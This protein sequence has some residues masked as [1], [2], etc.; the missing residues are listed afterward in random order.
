MLHGMEG[1]FSFSDFPVHNISE[2]SFPPMPDGNDSKI[3]YS[4]GVALLSL[5]DSISKGVVWYT[6]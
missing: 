5:I 4:R 1:S 2:M 6:K 3:D